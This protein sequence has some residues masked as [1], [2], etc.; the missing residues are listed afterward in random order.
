MHSSRG[1]GERVFVHG[2]LVIAYT[3]ICILVRLSDGSEVFFPLLRRGW[4]G[5]SL[6]EA[7]VSQ[8][9]FGLKLFKLLN[10]T[11]VGIGSWDQRPQMVPG[12]V[13]SVSFAL[14]QPH[15]GDRRCYSVVS[16][17]VDEHLPFSIKAIIDVVED[18]VEVGGQVVPLVV[19]DLK[20]I[21]KQSGRVRVLR[22]LSE[23]TYVLDSE[24]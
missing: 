16:L 17:P 11:A 9:D 7:W 3:V 1:P 6:L 13:V 20:L 24:P 22:V 2:V 12:F 8:G 10:E 4:E 15:Q 21:V 18:I 19:F 14:D 5:L 23:D